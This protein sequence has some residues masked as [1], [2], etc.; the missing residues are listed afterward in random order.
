MYIKL[1]AY[2]KNIYNMKILHNKL[3][4]LVASELFTLIIHFE[5]HK[6]CFENHNESEVDRRLF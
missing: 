2:K 4:A 3:R 5:G 6:Q 1:G